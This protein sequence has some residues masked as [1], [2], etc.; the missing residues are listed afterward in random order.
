[1]PNSK[2]SFATFE[3]LRRYVAE[4]LGKFESLKAEQFPL[5]EDVLF[6]SGK[7]CAIYFCLHGPRQVRLTAVWETD[8]NRILF[9]GS[10]G[11]RVQR[12]QLDSSP[13]LMA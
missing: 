5:T 3:E 1:M 2:Q 6:R 9:Y 11:R 13:K 4:T 12:R 8:E 7:P 10:C